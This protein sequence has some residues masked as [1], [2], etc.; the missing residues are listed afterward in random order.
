MCVLPEEQ[1]RSIDVVHRC[2]LGTQLDGAGPTALICEYPIFTLNSSEVTSCLLRD[3]TVL[4]H[5]VAVVRC[6]VRGHSG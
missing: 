5:F 3:R 6:P 4:P 1:G 2:L